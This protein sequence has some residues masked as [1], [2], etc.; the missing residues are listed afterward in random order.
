MNFTIG[1]APMGVA[2]FT[3]A[4][5]VDPGDPKSHATPGSG[6]PFWDGPQV[7]NGTSGSF[8]LVA[9]GLGCHTAFVE[10]W[11]NTGTNG[12]GSYGPVCYDNTPP[13]VSCGSPD[14]LWHATDA[15]IPCT[16]SDTP[17]GLAN[18]ADASFNLTTSVPNGT[19][20][21]N[22]FT[23]THSVCDKASNCTSAGPVGP[24]KVDKKPPT[25]VINQPTATQYV[26][27]ATFT[28]NYIVIDGG[29][30]VGTVTPTI[31]GSGTVGGHGLLSGQVINLLTDLSVG[32]HTFTVGA[33]DQVGNASS[34]SVIFNI[35]VTAQSIIADVNQFVSNGS[36]NNQGIANSL[37]AKLNAALQARNNG[38]CSA[39]ANIY[40]AFI[41]EVM[42]QSG[43]HISTSAAAIL[44]ADAQYLISH[45]P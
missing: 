32:Q 10:S 17:S 36:I 11:D 33:T 40:G 3:A 25:I 14:G 28:L 23:N 45:C 20:T 29:S 27:S 37:L 26:H 24:N 13:I 7:P 6:D 38:N 19:E 31:D 16:A 21:S 35:I 2:G 34:G 44:I 43:K 22:A 8:S 9:A 5:D 41:N 42:A 12:P 30:G 15:V 4:W 18:P 1:S 39:A